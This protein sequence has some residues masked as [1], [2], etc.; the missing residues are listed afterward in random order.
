[1]GVTYHKNKAK[2]IKQLAEYLKVK[3]NSNPPEIMDEI[4]TLPG[5]GPKVS[6][7]YQKICCDKLDGIVVDQNIKRISNRL[8]WGE[9]MTLENARIQLKE[10]LPEEELETINFNFLCFGQIMCLNT[11]P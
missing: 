3:Y 7:A 1:M 10:W 8:K 9:T 11:G 6:L 2:Y 4:F 5:I